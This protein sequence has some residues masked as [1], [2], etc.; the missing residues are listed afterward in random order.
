MTGSL[1]VSSGTLNANNN[2]TLVSNALGSIAP[3]ASVVAREK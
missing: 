3:V 2:L 1:A